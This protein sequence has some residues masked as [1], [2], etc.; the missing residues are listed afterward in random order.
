MKIGKLLARK[1][2]PPNPG[3]CVQ[4]PEINWIEYMLI[5][6]IINGFLELYSYELNTPI[7]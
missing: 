6:N 3:I 7:K 4:N 5:L 2:I 1:I